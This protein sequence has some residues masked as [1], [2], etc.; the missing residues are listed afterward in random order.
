[1]QSRL[2]GKLIL[3]AL[4]VCLDA[5]D[6]HVASRGRALPH[7][8]ILHAATCRK[9]GDTSK[10]AHAVSHMFLLQAAELS[11][12]SD[13]ICSQSLRVALLQQGFHMCATAGLCQH[14]LRPRQR[15]AIKMLALAGTFAPEQRVQGM[16]QHMM[17]R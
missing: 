14:R 9:A 13:D 12:Q 1:M 10:R 16:H 7:M 5:R 15:Q 11:L 2:L 8:L 17:D 6:W 3:Q 4:A